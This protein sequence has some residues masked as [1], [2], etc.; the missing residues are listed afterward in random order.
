MNEYAQFNVIE[1]IVAV[2]IVFAAIYVVSTMIG[3]PVIT[4]AST[5]SQLKVLAEDILRSL[6]EKNES[7]PDRYH[8]SLLVQCIAERDIDTLTQ[9][10][11]ESLPPTVLYNLYLYN[12]SNH[13]TVLLYPD[14]A[15]Q[16]VGTVE[17]ASRIIV[18]EGYIYEV[19][20]EVWAI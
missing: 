3:G 13:T 14:E 20:L 17:K 11:G 6:D 4:S 8:E 16:P 19:E 7:I 10:I 1:A 2:G 9:V 12:A 15:F 18:Y 5:A